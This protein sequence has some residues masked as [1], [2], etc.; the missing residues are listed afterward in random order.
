MTDVQTD[1]QREQGACLACG[2][3]WDEHLGIAGTCKMFSDLRS[4][5][6][7]SGDDVRLTLGM[8]VW[9][10]NSCGWFPSTVVGISKNTVT[11]EASTP[12]D[13][14]SVGACDVFVNKPK[15]R[16]EM[17]QVSI[18]KD[19]LID[20]QRNRI[21][22][23]ESDLRKILTEIP[24]TVEG[25]P[26]VI[27]G[28]VYVTEGYNPQWGVVLTIKADSVEVE[29]EGGCWTWS[30]LNCLHSTDVLQ[31]NQPERTN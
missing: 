21:D 17:E 31:Q 16:I 10:Q 26:I 27:G 5:L 30:S 12:G 2:V 18:N 24:T 25:D 8:V 11:V 3:P 7:L 20:L 28:P 19:E 13:V 22:Q 1:G 14:F 23:L 6:P 4:T 29:M 9:S 15:E